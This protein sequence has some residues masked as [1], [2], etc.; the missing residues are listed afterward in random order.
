MTSKSAG[1]E[2]S[3]TYEGRHIECQESDLVHPSHTDNMVDKGDPVLMGEN[4]VGVSFRSAA[5]ATDIVAVDTE[6]IWALSVTATDQYG[7]SAVARGD[8]LFI[9]KTTAIISKNYDKNVSVR[10]GVALSTLANGTGIVAVKVHMMPDD[11]I[12]QVGASGAYYDLSTAQNIYARQYRYTSSATAGAVQG[13]YIRQTQTGIGTATANSLRAYTEVLAAIGNAY[14]AHISLGFGELTTVG[15]LTG[16]GC[17][18]R[19]TLGFPDGAGVTGTLCALQ[20]E[21]FTFGANADL[22]TART[23]CIRVVNDG[24]AKGNVDDYAYLF[25]FVGWTKNAGHMIIT[26]TGNV[27]TLLKC[28]DVDGTDL[29]I[30]CTKTIT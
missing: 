13:I 9:N 12:E 20:A 22:S 14:G 30:M 24:S 2:I 25:E 19:S 7:A 1:D 27:D 8:V 5:L 16:L 26:D 6:G 11:Q 17:A 18:V 4:V 10:F 29:Y 3:S 28:C 21:I 15:K 23:S